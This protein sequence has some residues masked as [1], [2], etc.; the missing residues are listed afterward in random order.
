MEI[1]DAEEDEVREIFLGYPH[2]VFIK[3]FKPANS[4][5]QNLLI[6]YVLE[7]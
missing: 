7:S 5:T 6:A 3:I 2:E 4:K 1:V